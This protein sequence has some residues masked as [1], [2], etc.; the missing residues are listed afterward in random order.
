MHDQGEVYK[1][2]QEQLL[3]SDGW[4]EVALPRKGNYSLL[5]S[6][7]HR[8]LRRLEDL[9][10]KHKQMGVEEAHSEVIEQQKAE[11][12]VEAADQPAQGL[13]CYIPHKPVI[14]EEAAS[15][16]VHVVYDA[17]AKAHPNEWM[18]QGT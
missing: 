10:R 9:K 1:E 3:G 11:G 15:T 5:R 2:F 16:K 12:I 18:E 7:K 17:S 13:K 6:Y 8:S 4:Y 14:R